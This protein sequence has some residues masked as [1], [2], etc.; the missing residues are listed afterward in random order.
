MSQG[1]SETLPSVLSMNFPVYVDCYTIFTCWLWNRWVGKGTCIFLRLPGVIACVTCQPQSRSLDNCR[2]GALW[3]SCCILWKLRG[4]WH[5]LPFVRGHSQSLRTRF[6]LREICRPSRLWKETVKESLQ[7]ERPWAH[8]YDG[9]SP[10]TGGL[11]ATAG[12]LCDHERVIRWNASRSW[13]NS[14]AEQHKNH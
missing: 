11:T 1:L 9:H 6:Q 8:E 4:R 7:C 10:P 5:F 12:V 3:I 2:S 13:E 14:P